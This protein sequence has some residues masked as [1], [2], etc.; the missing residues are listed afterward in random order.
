MDSRLA[1]DLLWRKD[2]TPETLDTVKAGMRAAGAYLFT[3]DKAWRGMV[4]VDR[5]ME[6]AF[7]GAFEMFLVA[8]YL[9]GFCISTPWYAREGV[10]LFD[11][12]FLLKVESTGQSF[13][14]VIRA[15]EDIAR[16]TGCAGI[17]VGTALNHSDERLA[18]VYMR[19]GF[20]A[21]ATVLY[22]EI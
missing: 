9:V 8:G 11:E 16:V 6:A 18:S 13:R 10:R 17:A 5:A 14:R 3:G 19:H 22:K 12:Q 4:D 1:S 15:M 20:R 7:S 2:W 21:E